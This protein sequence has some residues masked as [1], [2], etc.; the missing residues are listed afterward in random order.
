MLDN[1]SLIHMNG[2]VFDPVIGRFVSAD[3]F[4]DV[5]VDAQG[6]NR[7]SYV[8]NNP[9]SFT[10]PTGFQTADIGRMDGMERVALMLEAGCTIGGC[11]F[12]N[13]IVA[14][15]WRTAGVRRSDD[16][17]TR[18]KELAQVSAGL[19][20]PSRS[21]NGIPRGAGAIGF[22]EAKAIA[23][24]IAK[25][26][27]KRTRTLTEKHGRG[28]HNDRY[29]AER[30]ARWV[31]RMSME[32]GS[33]WAGLFGFAHE[34]EGLLNTSRPQPLIEMRMD[35][36]NNKVG[37]QSAIQGRGAPTMDTPGLTFIEDGKLKKY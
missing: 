7:Y 16:E 33:G 20:G 28:G 32:I 1:L 25:E 34:I 26:E 21:R 12:R 19:E 29:D 18:K 15:G 27:L 36:N 13:P 35:L 22:F 8:K 31:Y 2:R 3:P 4:I 30:H 17:F 9:L 23:E 6:W 11:G 5:E 37:M 10:D 24:R 14:G